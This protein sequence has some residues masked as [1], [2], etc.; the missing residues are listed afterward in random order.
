VTY[1]LFIEEAVAAL[2][3]KIVEDLKVSDPQE[4]MKFKHIILKL[5]NIYKV[6]SST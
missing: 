5:N 1:C 3:N 2:G 6:F 4:G